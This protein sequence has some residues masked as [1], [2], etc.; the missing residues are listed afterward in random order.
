LGGEN[1]KPEF[2]K[3]TPPPPPP[4]VL[5]LMW[6][7]W[8]NSSITDCR[9]KYGNMDCNPSPYQTWHMHILLL[10]YGVGLSP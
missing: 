2:I 9:K 5:S 4:N 1:I 7:V 6:D 8:V 10:F 3:V